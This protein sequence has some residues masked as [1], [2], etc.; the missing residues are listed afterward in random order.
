VASTTLSKN[1]IYRAASSSEPGNFLHTCGNNGATLVK[2]IPV[3]PERNMLDA[4]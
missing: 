3:Y 2:S 1:T 4:P